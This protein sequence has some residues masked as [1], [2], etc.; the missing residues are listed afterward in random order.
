MAHEYSQSGRESN[1]AKGRPNKPGSSGFRWA[2][3]RARRRGQASP[4]LCESLIGGFYGC[5]ERWPGF[6]N[7]GKCSDSNPPACQKPSVGADSEWNRRLAGKCRAFEAYLRSA[8]FEEE[9]RIIKTKHTVLL[10]AGLVAGLALASSETFAAG[11]MIAPGALAT[12]SVGSAEAIVEK[13]VVV[14]R[15]RAVVRRPV[16]VHRRVVV[17]RPAVHRRVVR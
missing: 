15:R 16:A 7:F 5:T 13:T 4:L 2:R 6:W 3:G 17:R 12:T 11:P 10:A 8:I 14:V 1:G 9:E